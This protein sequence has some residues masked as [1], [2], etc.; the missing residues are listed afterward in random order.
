MGHSTDYVGL[1]AVLALVGA[2]QA[3][4]FELAEVEGSLSVSVVGSLAGAALFDYRAA[5]PTR[6]HDRRRRLERAPKLAAHGRLQHRHDGA[7]VARGRVRVHDL[8]RRP[9]TAAA[10]SSPR[11]GSPAARVYFL[12]NMGLLS[13]ASG[14]EGHESPWAVFH[15]RF[16]WLLPH[17]VVYG[18]I[19]A[20]MGIGYEAV[21]LYGLAVFAVPLLLMR[22][23]QEAYLKHTQK[24]AQ[25]L[26]E[27]AETIQS[28]NVS[29]EQ[30]N[31]AAPRALDRGDGVALG[32]RRRTRLVHRRPLAARAAARARDRPRARASRRRSSTCSATPRSSTTSASSRSRTRS[33]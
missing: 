18:F 32:H 30:A 15:E 26:R 20:V 3:L 21:G 23:T 4:S 28:Q 31:K 33:S 2:G 25:K 27:A 14:V 6:G 24:S 22:K 9:A 19:G 17:Y 29:L 8:G 16:A 7:V 5:L 1:L 13:F 10:S 12:V 11:S